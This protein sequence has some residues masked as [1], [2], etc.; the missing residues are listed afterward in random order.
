MAVSSRF[1]F[2]RRGYPTTDERAVLV[3]WLLAG[4]CGRQRWLPFASPGQHGSHLVGRGHWAIEVRL[5]RCKDVNFGEDASLIHV[6]Q[7]PTIMAL[8]RDA[9]VSLLHRAGVRR[10]ASRLRAHDQYS[11]RAGDESAGPLPT[12]AM[13]LWVDA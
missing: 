11:E 1:G 13:A 7:G 2:S 8:L 10:V 6:G 3:A 4:L 12:G 9:A 5:H